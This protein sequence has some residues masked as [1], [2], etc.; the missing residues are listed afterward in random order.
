MVAYL[1]L[2][3]SSACAQPDSNRLAP[4]QAQATESLREGDPGSSWLPWRLTWILSCHSQVWP[5]LWQ[6]S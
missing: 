5:N 1:E 3:S 6:L 4:G 2:H